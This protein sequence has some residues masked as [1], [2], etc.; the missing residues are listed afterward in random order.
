M[1]FS[2]EDKAQFERINFLLLEHAKQKVRDLK[3]KALGEGAAKVG[4]ELFKLKT[5][6]MGAECYWCKTSTAPGKIPSAKGTPGEVIGCCLKCHA[7]AC[8]D[9]A[10]RDAFKQE[11]KCFD[12]LF[13]MLVASSVNQADIS[14]EEEETLQKQ[15][16][17]FKIAYRH[18]DEVYNSFEELQMGQP[19]LANK[20]AKDI[21][22]PINLKIWPSHIRPILKKFSGDAKRFL[23]A[24]SKLSLSM[25]M[26]RTND[27]DE[28]DI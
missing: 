15:D 21:E 6:D 2:D 24:A 22:E 12:C 20:V 10:V 7:L 18:Q 1:H 28:L 17:S 14:K 11:F 16:D 8:G 27:I 4:A 9:H 19:E 25:K 3:D 5:Q 26:R 23:D 13:I